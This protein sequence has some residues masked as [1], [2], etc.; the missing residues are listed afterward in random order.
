MHVPKA[1]FCYL[2][3]ELTG[4]IIENW[5]VLRDFEWC[6]AFEDSPK[7]LFVGIVI[8]ANF[9]D[10]K[11]LYLIWPREVIRQLHLKNFQSVILSGEFR[12]VAETSFLV[13]PPTVTTVTWLDILRQISPSFAMADFT[14]VDPKG[15]E[16]DLHSV[17]FFVDVYLTRF[18][19]VK[20]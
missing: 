13:L 20:F 6:V 16:Y 7:V 18:R 8:M 4:C 19:D 17:R 15:W 5:F 14:L 2:T 9:E 12:R 11:K 10:M 3:S 1:I